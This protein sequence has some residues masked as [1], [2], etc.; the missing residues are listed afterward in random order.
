VPAYNEGHHIYENL[1]NISQKVEEIGKSYEIILID[2]GSI[3]NTHTA[4]LR[5]ADEN[6]NIKPYRIEPNRGKGHA[7]KEGFRKSTKNLITFIDADLDIPPEQLQVLIETFEKTNA[8]VIIQS[9][10]HPESIVN[11]F[12]LKRQILSRGYN[13]MLKTLFQLPVTDTQVGIKLYKREVL[14]QIMPKLLVKRYAA[15]VE[16]LLLA[17]KHGYTIA[18]TPAHINYKPNGDVIGP[19]DIFHIAWDTA[20]IFYRFK[21]KRYYDNGK[22][23]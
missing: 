19:K 11:N 1:H 13:Q 7:I 16:Q 10:R 4:A 12:P 14:E 5:A 17:Y 9:K 15:D 8:D 2:D 23:L 21:I 22:K 6:S 18:E 3:D 20:A